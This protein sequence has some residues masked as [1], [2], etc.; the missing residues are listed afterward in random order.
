MN[1][2]VLST[3]VL[4]NLAIS[5]S[6]WLIP[7]NMIILRNA[8]EGYN[9]KLKTASK[10]VVFGFIHINYEKSKAEPEKV[11]QQ[12]IPTQHLETLD[13]AKE[14]ENILIKQTKTKKIETDNSELVVILGLTVIS[15]FQL[16]KYGV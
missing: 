12:E 5:H 15:G 2:S 13:K 14:K 11:H 4:L 3:D 16:S 8:I 7:S 6:L 9:N 10:N 1:L